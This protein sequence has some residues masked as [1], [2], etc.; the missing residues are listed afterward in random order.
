MSVGGV[1][2][3]PSALEDR[4]GVQEVTPPRNQK[5]LGAAQMYEAQFLRQMLSE[6]RKTVPES[7]FLPEGPGERMYKTQ[8]GDQY[9]DTWVEKGGIGLQDLIYDQ[10][11]EKFFQKPLQRPQGPIPFG[12]QKNLQMKAAPASGGVQYQMRHPSGGVVGVQS[13]WAGEVEV[14]QRVDGDTT[15]LRLRHSDGRV[16][17]LGFNGTNDVKAGEKV[18]AGQRVGTWRSGGN[19]VLSWAALGA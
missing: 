3:R 4:G 2:S 18:E 9:V 17:L 5:V 15:V 11:M 12:N 7:E 6:M 10:L 1:G 16:S 14:S 19:T 13:P 8:L